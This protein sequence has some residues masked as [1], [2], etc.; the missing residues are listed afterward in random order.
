MNWMQSKTS[1]KRCAATISTSRTRARGLCLSCMLFQ[2]IGVSG[3]SRETLDDLISNIDDQD[4]DWQ[5]GDDQIPEEIECV[6]YYWEII[7]DNL[8]RRGW[9]LGWLSAVDSQGRTI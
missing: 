2:G 3:K 5:L 6:K 7:A 1:A 4:A 8:K 9:S